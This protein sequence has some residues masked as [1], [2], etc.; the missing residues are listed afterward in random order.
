ME[1]LSKSYQTTVEVL[2]LEIIFLIEATFLIT[3]LPFNKSFRTS[4]SDASS[5]KEH[6]S[7]MF[8]CLIILP[9]N[10]TNSEKNSSIISGQ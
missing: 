5:F 10:P 3:T 6:P 4:L 9:L 7:I 2:S 1:K 8:F